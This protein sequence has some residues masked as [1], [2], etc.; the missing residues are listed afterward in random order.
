MRHWTESPRQAKWRVKKI[1][2]LKALNALAVVEAAASVAAAYAQVMQRRQDNKC[3]H[4]KHD[5]EL[6]DGS[7]SIDMTCV[8]KYYEERKHQSDT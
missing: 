7:V 3:N 6:R 2:K 1:R 8:E 4:C 5:Y